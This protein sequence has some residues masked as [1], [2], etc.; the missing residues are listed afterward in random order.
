[1]KKKKKMENSR[2]T[3]HIRY[4]CFLNPEY[5]KLLA[6]YEFRADLSDF[7]ARQPKYTSLRN[8]FETRSYVEQ[9]RGV[10]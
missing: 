2:Y 10:L 3:N 1:M 8:F 9:I 5:F 4:L 7:L 6:D